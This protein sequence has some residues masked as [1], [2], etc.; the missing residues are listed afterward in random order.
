MRPVPK[1]LIS[2]HLT[3][4]HLLKKEKVFGSVGEDAGKWT[5]NIS[6]EST[7]TTDFL[8]GKLAVTLKLI[9]VS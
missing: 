8:E 4:L 3:F 1:N 5:L 2:P 7:G 9:G 6:S